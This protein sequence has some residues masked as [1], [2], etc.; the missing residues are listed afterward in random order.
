VNPSFANF[1]ICGI[2]PELE[3]KLEMM[4]STIIATGEF[5]ISPGCNVHVT[6]QEPEA[7]VEGCGDSDEAIPLERSF[8]ELFDCGNA[9]AGL[10]SNRKRTVEGRVSANSSLRLKKGKRQTGGAGMLAKHLDTLVG[11]VASRSSTVTS[12]VK[13]PEVPSLRAAVADMKTIPGMDI[14]GELFMWA[15]SFLEEKCKRE[16]YFELD[17]PEHK[18]NWLKYNFS[19][20][21]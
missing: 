1:R 20:K 16:V 9:E 17:L 3:Q 13:D 5:A 4:F 21:N 15:T 6:P 7:D 8:D 14:S 11:A 12:K 19:K 10:R 18:V 2:E